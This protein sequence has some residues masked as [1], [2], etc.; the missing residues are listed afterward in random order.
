MTTPKQHQATFSAKLPFRG[1]E[2]NPPP[3]A[4]I[5]TRFTY[6]SIAVQSA[7][8]PPPHHYFEAVFAQ[9]RR[10][11]A[12]IYVDDI[13]VCSAT[14]D[15]HAADLYDVLGL[16]KALG[17]KI[18]SPRSVFSQSRGFLGIDGE[19]EE[20]EEEEEEEDEEEEEGEEEKKEEEG[21]LDEKKL[22]QIMTLPSNPEATQT[23]D[24]LKMAPP[25]Q[26]TPSRR[27]DFTILS[28]V[29]DEESLLPSEL[30]HPGHWCQYAVTQ[31][32]GLS[33]IGGC[34]CVFL[35]SKMA[36][37]QQ[38]HPVPSSSPPKHPLNDEKSQPSVALY[39][40]EPPLLYTFFYPRGWYQRTVVYLFDLLSFCLLVAMIAGVTYLMK[41][42]LYIFRG[43]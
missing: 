25:T 36:P 14:V 6:L 37:L 11:Y 33:L 20:E 9:S 42:S 1:K 10:R 5:N 35:V 4:L 43:T 32:L 24:H 41:V 39:E 8:S 15:E 34:L 17:V 18:D 27:E 38:Q 7:D 3:P 13:L 30:F 26:Q 23:S 2:A 31:I 12:F 21:V 28:P 19:D 29:Y 16:V 22:T 40:G